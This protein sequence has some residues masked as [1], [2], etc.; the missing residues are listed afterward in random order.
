[1]SDRQHVWHDPSYPPNRVITQ[2]PTKLPKPGKSLRRV[3][4]IV[5]G[6]MLALALFAVVAIFGS[7]LV[8]GISE[9]ISD[10][11]MP[12][13]FSAD[14]EEAVRGL[15]TMIADRGK[16]GDF[17]AIIAMGENSDHLDET[18]LTA[19]VSQAFSDFDIK[20]WAIDHNNAQVL[21]DQESG[22][23]ILVF[24]IV[25]TGTD[26]ATRV[27]NPFYALEVDG[28]WRLTGILGRDVVEDVY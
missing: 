21:I 16:R 1:M 7:A 9:G 5:F 11:M 26:D 22:E 3:A 10:P 20:D 25:L 6:V 24:R 17:E 15:A 13:S 18:E 4:W 23:R 28:T 2:D 14:E 19:D 27:T 12:M 8:V